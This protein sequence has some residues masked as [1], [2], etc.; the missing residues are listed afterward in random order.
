MPPAAPPPCAAPPPFIRTA[1][2]TRCAGSHPE[3]PLI[4]SITS[5][6]TCGCSDGYRSLRWRGGMTL[7]IAAAAGAGSMFSASTR[8]RS[9]T[10]PSSSAASFGSI[11]ASSLTRMRAFSATAWLR[12]DVRGPAAA[13]TRRG[14]PSRPTRYSAEPSPAPAVMTLLPP[15]PPTPMPLMSSAMRILACSVARLRDMVASSSNKSGSRWSCCRNG[16][17]VPPP[18]SK[19]Q[20]GFCSC[21][22]G[23]TLVY[24]VLLAQ[25]KLENLNG[26]A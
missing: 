2:S 4:M 25:L 12:P 18:T 14:L 5:R 17:R 20:S 1:A 9:L 16:F 6:S 22:Q 11:R 13:L 23:L 3:L 26:I 8:A 19:N 24:F 21:F 7:T 10:Y 15:P